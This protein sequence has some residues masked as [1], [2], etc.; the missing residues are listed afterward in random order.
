MQLPHF[1]HTL[2]QP[3]SLESDK[4]PSDRKRQVFYRSYAD[5]PLAVRSSS[6]EQGHPAG[7]PF[8]LQK[9]EFGAGTRSCPS[10][11]LRI[12]K[13]DPLRPYRIDDQPALEK[14]PESAY[15]GRLCGRRSRWVYAAGRR[16]TTAVRKCLDVTQFG[17]IP[18]HQRRPWRALQASVRSARRWA[19]GRAL[20]RALG[21]AA[22]VGGRLEAPSAGCPQ[23]PAAYTS[24]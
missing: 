3:T 4:Q 23:P 16:C 24:H 9:L 21:G 1:G 22:A 14:S 11:R 6:P 20:M 7:R 18:G 5:G 17:P 8:C 15:G 19:L 13:N 10:M 2:G 12:Q